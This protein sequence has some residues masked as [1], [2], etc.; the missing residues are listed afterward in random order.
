M[1]FRI[2]FR[3]HF[4]LYQHMAGIYIHI[5]F[6]KQK[7][8]YCNFYSTTS[9]KYR[10]NFVEVLSN[11]LITRSEYLGNEKINT[12]YFGGGSPSLLSVDEIT[13]LI[14]TISNSYVVDDSVE[15][16]FEVNPDDLNKEKILDL[17]NYT[18]INRLSIGVQSFFDDDLY[19]LNR[20]HTA[21][22]A[23]EMIK[24]ALGAGFKNISIDLIY[25]IPTLSDHKWKENLNRFFEYS[26]PHLSSYSLTVEPKTAL[27]VLIKKNKIS[28]VVE[29]DIIKHFE[30]LLQETDK[31][32][33]I[34]YEISNFAIEG[35][36]SK[37]NSLYWLGGNYMGIGPSAHSYNG[38][39]RQWNIS[40]VGQYCEADTPKKL[41]NEKEVLNMDQLFNEYILTSMRTSW[42]CDIEHINNT[43]GEKYHKY[44]ITNIKKAIN[45]KMVL[46]NGNVFTLT[47]K[48]KFFA[49]G[50]S[51]S[52]FYGL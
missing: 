24:N 37:H 36:Y 29:S 32:S 51:S 34:H 14:T 11:E 45:E 1:T 52:L 16:T 30:I 43:F 35:Y 15:V 23:H 28:N 9:L 42:G 48:G 17:K 50:V 13:Y 7:C 20:I 21:R 22:Q 10:K 2:V 39:S 49:D 31:H 19:Y 27:S 18:L 4:E 44:F 41:I 12:I 25:G 33:F 3:L 38:K 40:S 26:I 6:C 5:P 46:R 47:K 8:H